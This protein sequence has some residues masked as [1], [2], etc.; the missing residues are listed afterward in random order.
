MNEELGGSFAGGCVFSILCAPCM[1][2]KRQTFREAY[3][4]DG[5][6]CMDCFANIFCHWCMICQMRNEIMSRGS[7]P[8][9]VMS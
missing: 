1:C 2:F 9:Q 5:N 4:I 7:P 6:L 8:N 3:N